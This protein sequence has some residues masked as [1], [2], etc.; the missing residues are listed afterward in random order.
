MSPFKSAYLEHQL[1]R[2][3]RPDAHLFIRPDWRRHVKP[4]SD[5]WSVYELYERKYS[6]D[7]PRD[8]HGRWTS[9]GAASGVRQS[10]AGSEKRIQLAA[11][12]TGFTRNGIN[13]AITRGVSPPAIQDAVVNQIQILPQAN[14]STRYVGVGAVVVRNPAGGV[15]TVWG[16]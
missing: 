8:N 5:L 10:P 7:Q 14:G 15:V 6:A 2:G 4:G 12:V 13:Q 11:D 1:K 16:K 3:M 9:E